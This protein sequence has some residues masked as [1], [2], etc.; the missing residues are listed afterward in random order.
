MG[1]L[2]ET[3][4]NGA[5]NI[6]AHIRGKKHRHQGTAKPHY[7]TDQNM[8]PGKRRPPAHKL[9][10]RP[11]PVGRLHGALQRGAL[12]GGPGG[13]IG[14]MVSCYQTGIDDGNVTYIWPQGVNHVMRGSPAEKA[15]FLPGDRVLAVKNPN[16]TYAALC[17][18]NPRGDDRPSQRHQADLNIRDIIAGG[19]PGKVYVFLVKP[20]GQAAPVQRLVTLGR[21]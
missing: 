10:E 15:G 4:A 2:A 8:T 14:I 3:L 1:S 16:G 6:A 12:L 11:R 17:Q 5:E 18:W 7:N 9:A 19:W 20:E 13:A 21:K